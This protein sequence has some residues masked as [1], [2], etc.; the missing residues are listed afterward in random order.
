MPGPHGKRGSRFLVVTVGLL[1]L[2]CTTVVAASCGSSTPTAYKQPA[3][4]D[5]SQLTW[6]QAFQKLQAKFSHEYAFTGWKGI[7][8][9]ALYKKYSPMIASA[10]AANDK[11]AYYLTLRQYI[12]ELRDGHASIKPDD[13]TVYQALAG[14]GFGLTV[15]RLDNGQV[16]ANWVKDGGPAAAAG[17]KL[18]AQIVNWDGKPVKTALAQTST[19]LSPPM[20]TNP[21][22]V[23]EQL[24]FLVRAPVGTDKSVVF[25]NP[26][27]TA[28]RTATIK[29]V[30]DAFETLAMT[31][32]RSA[33]TTGG[34]PTNMVEQ[35]MLPGNIGYV[36]VIAELDLPQGV[37]GDHAPTLE[38]FRNAINSFID[39]KAA[40]IIVD[41]RSNS[42]G[43]DSMVAE[44]MSSFYKAR[45]LY[46][47][48]NYIIPATGE[49]QIWVSDEAT[50]AYVK[51]GQGLYIE[52]G[53][54]IYTGPVV[55]LVNNGCISSGEGVA[56]GI[57]NLPNGKVVG[58]YG[59]N[60]SFG[61]A[62]DTAKMPG[63]YE[64]DWP[65]GQSLNK[66]KVVQVDSKNGQGGILP[67]KSI[68][69]TMENALGVAAGQDVLLDYGIKA[70]NQMR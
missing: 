60:G 57:K 68:P 35:K 14:G 48:Q 61:M 59:T 32:S 20:P 16:I 11:Q 58:F 27:E 33:I 51:P 26:G 49:F 44:F 4:A 17:M 7:S 55:A 8:W 50:G 21:R 53:K 66:D 37:P 41:V 65:F 3:P 42:G 2:A 46:E 45:T 39:S 52:A 10:Q 24:R 28:T 63:G 67:N 1:L 34:F 36:R 6:T 29:A 70:V 62:G 13:M 31:D 47:Y 5:Y 38:L 22:V 43:L 23:Y 25:K 56:M 69:M 30:S 54:K 40:G 15:T 12:N 19:V 9:S 18:G 64:I